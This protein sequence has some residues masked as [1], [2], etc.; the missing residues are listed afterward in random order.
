LRRQQRVL[1]R[2]LA[3]LPGADAVDIH[4]CRV[5]CRRLRSYLKVFSPFL[6]DEAALGY[7]K[8]LGAIAGLGAELHEL[9]VIAALPE[10]SREPF[11]AELCRARI[12]AT[13]ALRRRLSTPANQLRL[14]AA[15]ATPIGSLGLLRGVPLSAV[16]RRVRRTWRRA[17][18]PGRFSPQADET[19]HQ[20]RICLKNC[21]YALEIVSDISQGNSETLRRN[22]REAQQ[23]LGDRRDVAAAVEWVKT[24]RAP[25]RETQD[26]IESLARHSRRLDRRLGPTLRDLAI[27]GRRWDRAISRRLDRDRAVR[28]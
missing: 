8:L 23:L 21:R 15:V 19:L 13:R 12:R 28:S 1:A 25:A 20:L 27:A 5:A 14:A 11:A 26:A 16:L 7:R 18:E 3:R 24:C 2:S 6:E 4:Q 22:L 10:L 9:D 17:H